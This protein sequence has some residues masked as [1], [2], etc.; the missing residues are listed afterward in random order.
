MKSSCTSIAMC[1]LI[2]PFLGAAVKEMEASA[3]ADVCR[4]FQVPFVAVKVVTDV[5]D[6]DRPSHEEFLEN[7]QTAASSLQ[8]ITPQVIDYMLGKQMS[9]L[10]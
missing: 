7:L 8:S 2:E 5:V 10:C 9:D 4:I 1:S 6:G 3:I